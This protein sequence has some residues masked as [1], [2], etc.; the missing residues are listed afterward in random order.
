MTET[1][2]FESFS[3]P[4]FG[5]AARKHTLTPIQARGEL[6]MPQDGDRSR[7]PGVVIIEGLGGVDD[8][9][10][11]AYGALLARHD[12]ATL[13]V[14]S[15][16]SR[17]ARVYPDEIR[18]LLVTEAM[19][20]ADA[21][22]ALRFLRAHPEIDPDR[23][24]ILGFSYGGMISILTAY[25]QVRHLYAADGE[26]FAGHAAFYSASVIRLENTLTTGKP[27]LIM[28]GEKDD[29]VS[30]PRTREI[31][32]DLRRGGSEVCLEVLEGAYHQWNGGD[33]K[34]QF[35]RATLKESKA[36]LG[37]NN[38]MRDEKGGWRLKGRLSRALLLML[39]AG[40]SGYFIH[41]D[42]EATQR[43]NEKLLSFLRAATGG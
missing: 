3:P 8:E 16:G 5:R 35:V 25:E 23:I 28:L 20:C 24:C 43:S 17:G 22:G 31:A 29:N 9:R 39:R 2:F 32:D 30:I 19:M 34:R 41:R 38:V 11:R 26:M 10:E 27:L 1:V 12:Y 37:P 4:I 18:A 36:L 6:Y 13:V 42:D 40:Y 21:F 14:D 33:I 15:F 7:R